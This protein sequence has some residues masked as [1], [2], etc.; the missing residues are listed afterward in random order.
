[1]IRIHLSRILGEKR[2]TQSELSKMTGIRPNTI[3]SYYHEYVKRMNVEDLK[4]ICD[5]LNCK[6]SELLEYDP[7]DKKISPAMGLFIIT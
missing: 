7:R 2:M 1:M 6:L 3:N 4:K 5:A